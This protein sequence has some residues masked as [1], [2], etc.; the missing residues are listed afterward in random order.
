MDNFFLGLIEW[1]S[2]NDELEIKRK[3]SAESVRVE[4]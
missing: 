3:L 2:K 1:M 4:I